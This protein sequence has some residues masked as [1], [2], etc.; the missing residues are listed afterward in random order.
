MDYS[1]RGIE[2]KQHYIKSTSRRLVSKTRIT[3]FRLLIVLVVSVGIIGTFAG[4]GLIKGLIDSAPDI[5]KINVVP[6]GYTTT[7]YDKDGN[8]IENLIGAEANR[9]YVSLSDLPEWV[10]YSFIAIEDERFY[11]HNGIDVR[12]I[13]RAGVLGL[14]SG[15]FNQGG[16]TITQQLLKNQVFNGGREATFVERLKRK[17]QEQ[18]LAIQLENRLDKDTILEYYLNTINLG[19]GTLGIQT[20]S[21]K[22]FNK[23][24]KDLTLSE[25]ATI[26][27]DCP[28]SRVS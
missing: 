16:S 4:F 18:Y 20:A 24:A 10:K 13:L 7:V 17:I 19:S 6:T 12:G 9:V 22:Y 28:A 1:K 27:A 15:S 3:L 21:R 26:A 25:A 14:T 5:S 23:D 2:Q 11:E 8:V